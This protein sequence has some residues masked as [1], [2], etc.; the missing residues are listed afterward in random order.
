[1]DG[2]GEGVV[3]SRAAK[4]KNV[5]SCL[6]PSSPWLFHATISIYLILRLLS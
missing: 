6:S 1:M 5:L 4:G 3:G 2:G